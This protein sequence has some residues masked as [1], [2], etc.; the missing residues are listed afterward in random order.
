MGAGVVP[1]LKLKKYVTLLYLMP[2]HI[3]FFGYS[4]GLYLVSLNWNAEEA[5]IIV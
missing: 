2:R 3:W 4:L 5:A 1:E